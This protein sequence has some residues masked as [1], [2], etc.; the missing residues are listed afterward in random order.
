M[1][2]NALIWALGVS[3]GIHALLALLLPGFQFDAIN[4]K[5]DIL[6]VELIQPKPPEP[7]AIPEPP[8]PEP[9]PE[10]IKKTIEPKPIPKP[11]VK[12]IE[13]PS[14]IKQEPPPVQAP[15]VADTPPKVIAAEPK[16][17]ATPHEVIQ[18]PPIEK[19]KPEP[20]RADMENALGEYTGLLGR[21]IAKHK[22]Y[23]RIAQMRGWQGDVIL[24]LKIDG[25]GN[26]I[27]AKVRESS[28]HDALDNQALEMVKKAAPFPQPPEA[29]RNGNF[30]ITVPVSFKLESA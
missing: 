13:A 18:Q 15:T 8:K 2:E 1:Q 24:D 10:P 29:L 25:N 27:S 28:G 14:P 7:V 23:P 22:Q 20:N 3:F 9:T 11:I 5:I 4:K 17:D 16:A 30:N 12:K 21:A 26:V 6:S 19:V